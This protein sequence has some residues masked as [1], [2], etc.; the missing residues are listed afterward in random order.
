MG[1]CAAPHRESMDAGGLWGTSPPGTARVSWVGRSP[2]A[3][4]RCC[5]RER[6]AQQSRGDPF[7]GGQD[8]LA[9]LGQPQAVAKL[10]ACPCL[11]PETRWGSSSFLHR[12]SQSNLSNGPEKASPNSSWDPELKIFLTEILKHHEIQKSSL[13]LC[14]ISCRTL[15]FHGQRT[16]DFLQPPLMFLIVQAL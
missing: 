16:A 1:G 8:S 3:G 14:I 4:E 10:L 7:W 12:P 11:V 13:N 9:V 2:S 15:I 5:S 6:T